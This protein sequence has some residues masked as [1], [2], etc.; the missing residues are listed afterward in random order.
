MAMGKTKVTLQRVGESYRVIELVNCITPHVGST[1][2]EAE[3][4]RLII[5]A[6]HS[7]GSVVIKDK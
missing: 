2:S 3:A 1:V 4:K 7:G 6:R 5:E